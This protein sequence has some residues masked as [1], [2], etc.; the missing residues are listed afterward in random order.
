MKTKKITLDKTYTVYLGWHEFKLSPRT[1]QGL[2][3]LSPFVAVPKKFFHASLVVFAS[4]STPH[5]SYDPRFFGDVGGRK[6]MT[7][8]G[9]STLETA[10]VPALSKMFSGYV[11]GEINRSADRKLG[12]KLKW[13]KLPI[14]DITRLLSLVDNFNKAN[15]NGPL[16]YTFHGGLQHYN[17]SSYMRGLLNAYGLKTFNKSLACIGWNNPVPSHYFY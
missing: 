7:V 13:E 12:I 10:S 15:A 1:W 16:I 17:S 3:M 2:S 9:T 8:G 11:K 14:T 5:Y 4:E 6:Y